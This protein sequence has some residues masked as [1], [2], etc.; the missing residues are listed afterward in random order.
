VRQE[1]GEERTMQVQQLLDRKG[2]RIITL[3]CLLP[4]L[5]IARVMAAEHIGTVMMAEED[6]HLVGIVSERDI[7]RWIA[8]N[9][10]DIGTLRGSD[11]MSRTLVTCSPD[12][13]L[14]DVLRMMSAHTIRHLPVVREGTVLGL[15][16]VRDVLDL[17]RDLFIDDM[18]RRRETEAAM[19]LAKDEAELASRTKTEFLANM[20]HEL[21]TPLHAIVGFSE[22]LKTEAFGPL[23]SPRNREFVA[24]IHRSGTHLL[25]IINDILDISRIETGD[26]R[27]SDGR[28][29]IPRM[30]ESCMRLIAERARDADV[31]IRREISSSG[32]EIVG[33]A[34][35]VKQTLMNLLDNAVKFTRPGGTVTVGTAIAVD[36]GLELSVS[37]TGIGMAAGDIDRA[38]APFGQIDGS[39]SRKFGGPGLGLTLVNAMMRV[40]DGAV[41]IASTPGTGT[42]VSLHFPAARVRSGDG[43]RLSA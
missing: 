9:G 26:R 20:S 5:E 17:Q 8:G 34:R 42:T 2:A 43:R 1:N 15:I 16:S 35:M 27:P 29:D 12:T 30:I 31:E 32:A 37:D 6:G 19:R 3:S 33:D 41:R 10:G 14:E 39:L 7:V 13:D 18:E 40:H 25:E 21:R 36:G 24:E 11:L 4:V 38:L 23:G 28:I 22:S